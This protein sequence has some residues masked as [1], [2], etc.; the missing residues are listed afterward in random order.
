MIGGHM[1]IK[2]MLTAAVQTHV[3]RVR[4]NNEDNFYLEG[5][6]RSDVS[7]KEIKAQWSGKDHRFLAAVADGMG[8]EDRGET[9]SLI[10]VENLFDCA[11]EELPGAALDCV[12]R[13]NRQ[14]CAEI[15]QNGGRRMGSTLAALYIDDGKALCC[16]VG[17]SRV[18]LLRDG[19]LTQVSVDHNRA[20]SMVELGVLTPEQAETHPSRHELTQH[21]GIFE[22]EMVLEPELYGPVELRPGDLFLLCSDGMTDSVRDGELASRLAQGGS[23]EQQVEDLVGLA[24]SR[25]G[26]DNITVA[27]V[28]VE[29]RPSLFPWGG[30]L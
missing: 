29:K 12:Q 4:A 27:V 16:N 2:W 9:A 19:V 11:M 13:A 3:G 6:I 5:Q 28:Q 23:P 22:E 24:L 7:Q 21:L 26:R 10:T 17:D 8:G 20:R 15:E 14:I 30:A 18:Y 1:G 25:G